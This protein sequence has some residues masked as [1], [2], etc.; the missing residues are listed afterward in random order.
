MKCPNCGADVP[1]GDLFCGECGNRIVPEERP[2]PPPPLTSPPAKEPKRGLPKGLLIGAGGLLAL[3]IIA[4]CILAALKIFG[5]SD[6]T[7]TIAPTQVVQKPTDTPT[8][9]PTDTPSPLPTLSPTPTP[10]PPPPAPPTPRPSTT[11]PK[12]QRKPNKAL[13]RVGGGALRTES[14]GA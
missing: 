9:A 12:G 8:L 10:T 11:Q 2:S 14:G 1:T 6:P 3:I 7:P 13:P 5:A 4:G